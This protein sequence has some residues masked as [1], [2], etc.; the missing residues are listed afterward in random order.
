MSDYAVDVSALQADAR[1]WMGWADELDRIEEHV[2]YVDSAIFGT[3]LGVDKVYTA[4]TKGLQTLRT[5]IDS[6]H[7]EFAGIADALG[8]SASA[9]AE[10]DSELSVDAWR[11]A[12]RLGCA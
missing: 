1:A 5:Y 9:Y 8:R 6:G 2:P 7:G 4:F 11:T 12:R 3:V 10:N